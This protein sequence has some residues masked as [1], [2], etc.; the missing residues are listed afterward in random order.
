MRLN[1]RFFFRIVDK[2]KREELIIFKCDLISVR[3]VYLGLI[4]LFELEK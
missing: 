2:Q 1:C 4:A 3:T